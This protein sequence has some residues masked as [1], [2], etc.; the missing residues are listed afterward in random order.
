[1]LISFTHLLIQYTWDHKYQLLYPVADHP[2][3]AGDNCNTKM[4]EIIDNWIKILSKPIFQA[5]EA[6]NILILSRY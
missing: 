1:M 6:P 4:L 3:T 5:I 2:K